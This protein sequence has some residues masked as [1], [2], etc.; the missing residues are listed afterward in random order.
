MI[1]KINIYWENKTSLSNYSDN[2]REPSDDNPFNK[3]HLINGSSKNVGKG[4]SN[5]EQVWSNYVRSMTQKIE[6]GVVENL[7]ILNRSWEI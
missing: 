3:T 1:Q 7:R 2:F 6:E 4:L 5:M